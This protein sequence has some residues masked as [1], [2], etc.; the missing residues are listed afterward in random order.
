M[1]CNRWAPRRLMLV[2]RAERRAVEAARETPGGI[3][4]ALTPDEARML[5]AYR[6]RKRAKLK[7]AAEGVR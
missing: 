5:A 1:T 7:R 2:R 4:Q 3:L 6:A